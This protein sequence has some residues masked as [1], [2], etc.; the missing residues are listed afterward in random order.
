MDNIL[1]VLPLLTKECYMASVDLRDA[2]YSI[3]IHAESRKYLRF[4]WDQE[5]W[6]F[7]A[8]PNGL[9]SAPRLFTKM[10]KPLLASLRQKGHT[11]VAYLDDTIIIGDTESATKQA[12]TATTE[13]FSSLGFIIHPEKS[14]L[15][16][17]Q[18]IEFLGFKLNTKNMKISLP[19]SKAKD[20][21]EVCIGLLEK[22][23]PSIREV[24]KVIGK[25]VATFPAS[26][27]GPLH[28]RT[29][30]RDK[31]NALKSNK[32]HFDRKM[33]LS[34]GAVREIKWWVSSVGL[35]WSPISRDK[36][37]KE[38]RTDASGKGWGAT[39]MVSYAGGRWNEAELRKAEN[40]EINFLETLAAFHG[41]K[42]FCSHMRDTH[43]LLRLDNTTAVAYIN[44]M[45]GTKSLP[46]NKV[47]L[48]IWGWCSKRNIWVSAAH[49]P[50]S[51]NTAADA[52]SRKFNDNVEWMLD[53][54]VFS[55]I[56]QR[57]GVPDV[58]LFASRL[59]TQL[60]TYVSWMPDP[61]AW[62]VDAF[63]I[64]WGKIR[65]YAFPPFCLITKCLQKV[66]QDGASG[67]II[68]PN[69]PTQ[70]WYP[71][72][73]NMLLEEPMPLPKGNVLIQPISGQP[74]PLKKLFLI[75]CRIGTD[76][77]QPKA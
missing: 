12:I 43:I 23:R 19:Q 58:D 28:Y 72:L 9:S 37:T 25:L 51:Q 20:I 66:R 74:H 67:I 56:V 18:E 7:K 44:N 47:A 64:D 76:S 29:L 17:S 32:G 70:P 26:Q 22:K 30:E 49:L 68:V 2:Y 3:P 61:G 14:V 39:D 62:A 55:T 73:H 69:W 34:A 52:L 42:S 16:P 33:T 63:S 13:L 15:Q 6:Q 38:I 24:A 46:C 50:G 31:T 53:R 11:V 60:P 75:C 21:K 54:E 36:P 4:M 41:L 8:L 1:S 40:N 48:E 59:N 45:G 10:T 57:F 77:S 35:G 5:L 65:F 27:F 71:M